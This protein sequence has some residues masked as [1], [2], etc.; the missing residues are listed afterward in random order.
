MGASIY[1][2]PRLKDF[3]LDP[4]K[5]HLNHGSYGAVPKALTEAQDLWRAR[6]ESNPSSFF[7]SELPLLLRQ[8]AE[9]VAD[10]FGGR[11]E[12]WV[13]V[14]NAT[15]GANAAIPALS[16]AE[17][18]HVLATAE[19][20]NAVRQ[21]LR[22]FAG[23]HG[24]DVE[25]LTLPIP[26]QSEDQLLMAFERA[27][28]PNTKAI[29]VDHVT[30]RSALVLPVARI[31]ALARKNGLAL[32]VDGA[33]A[34][35]MVDIDVAAIGADWYVG[36]A[37]KWLYAPRGCALFWTAPHRQAATHPVVISHGYQQGYTA[38][39][40]WIG[41]RDYSAWLSISAALD[42]HESEGGTDLRTRS[43]CLAQ[44]MGA[45][46]ATALG[47]ELTGPPEL[48]GAMAA[49]RLPGPASRCALSRAVAMDQAHDI[50][51]SINAIDGA[52][53]LRVSAAL[54]NELSDI[55]S[56]LEALAL[57]AE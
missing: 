36:N 29:F 21:A 55:D 53:W 57:T 35:G 11:G 39:F 27:I 49:V 10:C 4:A 22:H 8:A 13:F 9:R 6:I 32:F 31:A 15:Q 45:K 56:L 41:T 43:R 34:P 19:I 25:E 30:S 3:V 54:Y 52:D 28:R 12:D 23:R 1:G 26:L 14:E 5:V 18:D 46:L 44:G 51:V 16:L 48:I 42:W 47:T 38:E 40:D 17:G 7:R 24:V 20:Y 33:H 2:H 50:M 37:H